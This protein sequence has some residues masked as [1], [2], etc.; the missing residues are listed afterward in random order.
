[1]PTFRV[2]KSDLLTE[3]LRGALDVGVAKR[4]NRGADPGQFE[5]AKLVGA[6]LLL[7]AVPVGVLAGEV[8]EHRHLGAGAEVRDLVA[9]QLADDPG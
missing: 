8:G 9:R 1:M 5:E 3:I 4:A 2:G 6:I 7:A